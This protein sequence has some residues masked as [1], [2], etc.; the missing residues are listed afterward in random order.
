MS[1]FQVCPTR[2][3]VIVGAAA[4][5]LT[6]SRHAW[7]QARPPVKI[8]FIGSGR[9]QDS[10]VA[11]DGL[12]HGLTA[13]GWH[14]AQGFVIEPRFAYSDS[15]RIQE[16]VE[17]LEA[18]GVRL[19]VTHAQAVASVVKARRNVPAVYQLSADPVTLG[20][21]DD[22]ARPLNNATGVTL[23]AAEL[24]GKRLELLREIVPNSRTLAVV[25]NP[26]HAGEHLER[27]WIERSAGIL[28][29]SVRYLSTRQPAELDV[30]FSE[31]ERQPPSALVLFSDGFLLAHRA[32]VM[33]AASAL[34]VPTIAGWGVFA[35][36]GALF[37]Y[38]PNLQDTSRRPAY[39]VDRILKG[40][41]A[42]DLPI[43]QPTR[44]ELVVNLAAAGRLGVAVP[45]TVVARADRVIE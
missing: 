4:G 35:E 16:L 23:L 37:S 2:R 26:Q 13:L 9:P 12:L 42:A 3:A 40:A 29:F 34:N 36:A 32:A 21:T 18:A 25:Y 31:I 11:I 27:S 30:A 33:R 22:L 10:A 43:E 7:A 17:Q 6:G 44:L 14:E 24:N 5:A 45:Q 41:K 15:A 28:D 38:G 1:I 19:I 39:F 20:L 8:G